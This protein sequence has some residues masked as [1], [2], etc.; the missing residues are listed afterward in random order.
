MKKKLLRFS[1]TKVILCLQAV[2]N[3]KQNMSEHKTAKL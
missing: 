2:P 1:I 3:Q